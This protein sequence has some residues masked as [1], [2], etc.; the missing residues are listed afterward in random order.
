MS[1]VRAGQGPLLTRVGET[2]SPPH[3][4]LI[5]AR[6]LVTACRDLGSSSPA[7]TSSDD[8]NASPL[9]LGGS[10]VTGLL[11]WLR[12]KFGPPSS[13]PPGCWIGAR[14]L[15]RAEGTHSAKGTTAEMAAC[16]LIGG[17]HPELMIIGSGFSIR[18]QMLAN[19]QRFIRSE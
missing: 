11:E 2:P 3:H 8:D 17:Q 15:M 14:S 9:K 1:P 19:I 7:A 6:S 13:P 18:R 16:L 12:L 10:M 5:G 4:C